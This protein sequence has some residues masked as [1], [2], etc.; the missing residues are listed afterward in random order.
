MVI[1]HARMAMTEAGQAEG[2]ITVAADIT[3][4]QVSAAMDSPA[5]AA[6]QLP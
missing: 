6:V 1:R 4:A 2:S 5:A 3:A